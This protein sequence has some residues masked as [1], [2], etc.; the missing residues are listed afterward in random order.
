MTVSVVVVTFDAGRWLEDC[1]GSLRR[2][3]MP[4]RVE[5]VDNGSTDGTVESIRSSFP[6]VRL[7]RMER[8]LG[9]SKANNVGIRRAYE[10][11]AEHVFLLNQD[12]WVE[13]DT[14]EGLV[15]VQRSNPEFGVLSPIHLNGEG[16]RLD[17]AFA[18]YISRP[19][20]EGRDL[21]THLLKGEPLRSVYSVRFVNAAAWLISRACLARVGLFDDVLFEHYGE[22]DNYLQRVR[23]HGLKVGVVP[24]LFIR[25]DRE[26]RA[27]EKVDSALTAGKGTLEFRI[28]GSNLLDPSAPERMKTET[29]QELY[30]ALKS[31]LELDLRGARARWSLFRQKRALQ[32]LILE[33]REANAREFDAGSR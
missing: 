3:S 11:G 23:F 21:Y 27:G 4:V 17:H 31:A 24:T 22:D 32:G 26:D 29:R 1:L 8:N 14:I 6:E 13:P 33:R 18:A 30:R 15:E 7:T 16:D 20:D 10:G 12:A 5:V 9:F 2:S 19:D 28:L 25:H